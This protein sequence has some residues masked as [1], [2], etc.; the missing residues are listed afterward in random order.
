[1]TNPPPTAAAPQEV[2]KVPDATPITSL[3][4]D[5]SHPDPNPDSIRTEEPAW[6]WFLFV[7]IVIGLINLIAAIFIM[8]HT[9]PHIRHKGGQHGS[10]EHGEAHGEASHGEPDDTE[11][12]IYKSLKRATLLL[13]IR[14]GE[15]DYL[16]EKEDETRHDTHPLPVV[17]RRST[18]NTH[19]AIEEAHRNEH[20]FAFYTSGTDLV[21]TALVLLNLFYSVIQD[22]TL[23]PDAVC[24]GFGFATFSLINMDCMLVAYEAILSYLAVCAPAENRKKGRYHWRVW[25]ILI[26]IPWALSVMLLKSKAFGSDIFW[27]F[28]D[29]TGKAGKTALA[30]MCAIHYTVLVVVV[31]TYLPMIAI[32]AKHPQG[33]QPSEASKARARAAKVT[34]VHLLVHVLHYTPGTFHAFAGF[35]GYE[36]FW[37]YVMA[38]VSLQMGAI[39]HSIVILWA[40]RSEKRHQRKALA[41][42]MVAATTGTHEN[43]STT[44]LPPYPGPQGQAPG[45]HV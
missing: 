27:C 29:P 17:G 42:E 38:I 30:F 6:R 36:P 13:P 19:L 31:M 10:A 23:R 24:Q 2:T 8:V 15:L 20:R 3:L 16:E 39:V 5:I 14:Q 9:V 11:G 43:G 44:S 26:I 34:A 7:G 18:V 33:Y 21:L 37:V 12:A 25:L 1:V 28:V 22:H 45:Y 40:G 35:V 32:R 4:D 41:R